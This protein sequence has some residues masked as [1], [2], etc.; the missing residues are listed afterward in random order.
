MAAKQLPGRSATHDGLF[1]Y[2]PDPASD[3][4]FLLD[5]QRAITSTNKT[6]S[7]L[8]GFPAPSDPTCIGGARQRATRV[9]P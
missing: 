1:R 4:A 7:H 5:D 2:V 3:P 9:H 6:T 8:Q